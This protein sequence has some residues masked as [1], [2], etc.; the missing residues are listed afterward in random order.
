MHDGSIPDA[1]KAA[2]GRLEVASGAATSSFL[3]GPSRGAL[4]LCESLGVPLE[5]ASSRAR[6]R[7]IFIDGKLRALPMN[8][9]SRGG[10]IV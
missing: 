6:R 8:P 2:Q 10:S 4:A 9:S 7:W 5:Q 1:S 3:D